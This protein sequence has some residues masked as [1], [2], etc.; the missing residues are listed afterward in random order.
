[1][2]FLIISFM[3]LDDTIIGGAIIFLN[4]LGVYDVVLPFLLVFTIVFAI[5]EKTQIFGLEKI[6]GKEVTKKGLNAMVAFVIAFF[7]VASS[8]LVQIIA[9]VSS[10]AVVLLLSV[11]LFLL[12]IGT[13]FK[14]EEQTVLEGKWRAFFMVILFIGLVLL[15]LNAIKSNGKSWLEIFIKFMV[16]YASSAAVAS[17]IL[18]IFIIA[19]I[20][21]IT[22]ESE[23]NH[24]GKKKD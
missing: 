7:V 8:Q 16:E 4:K 6:G 15:F 17:I 3:A 19:F 21:W 22:R 12:L 13:F 2:R 5:F 18:I 1:M 20:V 9:D 24:E 14:H 11:I 23:H 10:Q